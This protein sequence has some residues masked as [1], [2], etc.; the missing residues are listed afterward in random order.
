MGS[1]VLPDIILE[2]SFNLGPQQSKVERCLQADNLLKP[3][4]TLWYIKYKDIYFAS[5][6]WAFHHLPVNVWSAGNALLL[7]V[8]RGRSTFAPF[9]DEEIDTTM[10]KNSTLMYIA[11]SSK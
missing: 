7:T 9:T 5:A 2:E 1:K 8:G 10:L 3:N 6:V 4:I 11:T